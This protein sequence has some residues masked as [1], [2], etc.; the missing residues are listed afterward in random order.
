M[1]Q[2][3]VNGEPEYYTPRELSRKLNVSLKWVTN[4]TQKRQVPGQTKIGHIWRYKK[5]EVE[6][7]LLSGRFLS[8]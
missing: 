5:I 7:G 8:D 3:N 1:I 6:K 4:R 2:E